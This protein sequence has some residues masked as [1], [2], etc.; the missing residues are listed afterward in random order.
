M[1][2]SWDVQPS[3][4]RSKTGSGR[5]GQVSEP[6]VTASQVLAGGGTGFLV[7]HTVTQ[8]VGF[9]TVLFA[10]S[11]FAIRL[12]LTRARGH[13]AG[14]YRYDYSYQPTTREQGPVIKQVSDAHEPPARAA[15]QGTQ[16]IASTP[17]GCVPTGDAPDL[18][19]SE[20]RCRPM[21]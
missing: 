9:V 19:H 10:T 4:S 7:L 20:R 15:R 3:D 21:A 17:P 16:R 2:P 1:P 11:A 8:T 14:H 12:L 6:Q 13:D 18:R 5:R